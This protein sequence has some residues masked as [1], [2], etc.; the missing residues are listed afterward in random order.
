MKCPEDIMSPPPPGSPGTAIACSMSACLILSA[1]LR[2]SSCAFSLILY[3]LRSSLIRG[4][5]VST[6]GLCSLGFRVR[7]QGL[8]V[9]VWV[10]AWSSEACACQQQASVLMIRATHCYYC[11]V[12]PPRSRQSTS[13]PHV[14]PAVSF[15]GS[16]ALT[17]LFSVPELRTAYSI[18]RLSKLL[19]CCDALRRSCSTL[20]RSLP[21]RAD[22]DAACTGPRAAPAPPERSAGYPGCPRSR[23]LA[24]GLAARPPVPVHRF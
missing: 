16:N 9:R 11:P 8:E 10:L 7:A 6:T 15:S 20:V 12:C 22:R 21:S 3:M 1:F 4:T 2:V 13:S 24:R 19:A 17:Q 14:S 18:F 23:R 5:C